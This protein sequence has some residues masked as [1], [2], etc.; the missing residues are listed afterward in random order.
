MFAPEPG[1]TGRRRLVRH[2]REDQEAALIRTPQG[3]AFA[4]VLVLRDRILDGASP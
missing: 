1:G 3:F 4:P 2:L